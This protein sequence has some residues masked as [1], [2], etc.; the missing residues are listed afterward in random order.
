MTAPALLSYTS[1]REYANT[2]AFTDVRLE[3]AVPPHFVRE[4]FE[5][6][7]LDKNAGT[8]ALIKKVHVLGLEDEWGIVDDR[9]ILDTLD[10]TFDESSSMS[11]SSVYR[12]VCIKKDLRA[13]V[14]AGSTWAIAEYDTMDPDLLQLHTEAYRVPLP[15]TVIQRM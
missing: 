3:T 6:A 14:R 9:A 11:T 15:V 1:I 7:T 12:N 2:A 13:D 4:E 8:L 5:A 10:G